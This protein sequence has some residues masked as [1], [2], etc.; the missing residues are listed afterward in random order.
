MSKSPDAFRTIREVADWLGVAAHV[1]RFWESK[2]S[3]IKPVKRAGGRRYYRPADMELVGGIKVLLHD[4]GMTVRGVQRL[5]REEGV[6]AI[7]AL[8]PPIDSMVVPPELVE[9]IADEAAWHDDARAEAK[10]ASAPSEKP[11]KELSEVEADESAE[12]P[13]TPDAQD[14]ASQDAPL[15]LGDA[16]AIAEDAVSPELADDLGEPV[17]AATDDVDP[18]TE[19]TSTSG[20]ESA[21]AEEPESL[22]DTA[23]ADGP[24]TEADTEPPPEP[25]PD[26]EPAPKPA[27]TPAAVAAPGLDRL[28]AFVAAAKDMPNAKRAKLGPSIQALRRLKDR[29]DE[30]VDGSNR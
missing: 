30:P 15:T 6:A 19:I 22:R 13:Y 5:L 12:A 14:P 9:G 16:E 4:R 21:P 11:A 27:K 29:M 17:V 24:M 8:S 28:A 23:P 3:H 2:F 25:T 20:E 7:A 18:S 10:A 26:V 1:L